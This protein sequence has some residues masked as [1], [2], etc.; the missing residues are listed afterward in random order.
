MK[1]SSTPFNKTMPLKNSFS[2]LAGLHNNLIINNTQVE[3]V[4]FKVGTLETRLNFLKQDHSRG[5]VQGS[6]KQVHSSEV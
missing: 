5:F 4:I 1:V 6:P 3:I 2:S